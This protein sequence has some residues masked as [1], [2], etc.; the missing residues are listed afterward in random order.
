MSISAC[1]S[2]ESPNGTQ[3]SPSST[4]RRRERGGATTD[5]ERHRLLHSGGIDEH[6]TEV[7]ELAMELRQ[8][9][10][11]ALPERA[12]GFVAAPRTVVERHAQQLELGLERSH[13]DPEDDPASRRTRSRVP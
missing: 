7:V 9:A 5:P 3:P 11:E 2:V 13:P 4:A 6:A 12:Q 1:S 10:P 8:A